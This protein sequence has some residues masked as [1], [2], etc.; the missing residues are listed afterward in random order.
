MPGRAGSPLP[1]EGGGGTSAGAQRSD[2]LYQLRQAPATAFNM[3]QQTGIAENL[4]LL[5]DLIADVTVA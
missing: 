4:K 3:N 2:A 5:A 1:A